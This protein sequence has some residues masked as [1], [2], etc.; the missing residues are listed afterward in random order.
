[1][2]AF[3]K[4]ILVK[5][6]KEEVKNKAGIIIT[7]VNDRE[8]RYKLGSVHSIGDSVKGVKEGDSLYYDKMSASEIRVEGEKL[9]VIQETDV[10]VIL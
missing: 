2:K 9:L 1:M 5:P 6:I 8:I 7:D 3:G 4:T 10:R